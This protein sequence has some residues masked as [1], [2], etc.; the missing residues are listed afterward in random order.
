MRHTRT[1]VAFLATALLAVSTPCGMAMAMVESDAGAMHDCPHCPPPPC[2][3]DD[4]ADECD[5]LDALDKPRDDRTLPDPDDSAAPLLTL[6]AGG[7]TADHPAIRRAARA[8]PDP[9]GPRRH[10]LLVTFNE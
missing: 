1:L 4:T 8:P 7:I 9:M 10:L 3:A 2:H 6:N 5:A